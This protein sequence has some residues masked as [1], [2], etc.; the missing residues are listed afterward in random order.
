M[1]FSRALHKQHKWILG[2]ADVMSR[3]IMCFA[4]GIISHQQQ[5]CSFETMDRFTLYSSTLV[6]LSC[7]VWLKIQW[8]LHH[9]ILQ[10]CKSRSIRWTYTLSY[11]H[12]QI[13][14]MNYYP[15]LQTVHHTTFA[16]NGWRLCHL[17][18]LCCCVHIAAETVGCWVVSFLSER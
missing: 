5:F 6:N 3:E 4:K 18:A 2:K 17:I 11:H 12:H 15:L 8:Q 9:K 16:D 10:T 1:L 13:G 14:C 7:V